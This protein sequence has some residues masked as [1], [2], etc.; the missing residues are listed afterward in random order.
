MHQRLWLT[1]S[2]HNMSPKIILY[3]NHRCPYAQ[4]AHITL[5]TLN[6]SPSPFHT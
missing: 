2:S 6:L 4:R 5:D 1:K 3:T